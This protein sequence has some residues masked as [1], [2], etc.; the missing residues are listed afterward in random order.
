MLKRY[1]P[2]NDTHVI[3]THE[4]GKI[5]VKTPNDLYGP[6]SSHN[7]ALNKL[8]QVLGMKSNAQPIDNYI[9]N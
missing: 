7:V 6:Y 9:N 5:Y 8:K 4:S 1:L 3:E 2:F